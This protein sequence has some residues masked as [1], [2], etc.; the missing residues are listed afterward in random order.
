MTEIINPD[1]NSKTCI[2]IDGKNMV[3]CNKSSETYKFIK[4]GKNYVIEL[5]NTKTILNVKC[6]YAAVRAADMEIVTA[7]VDGKR[8]QN[9]EDCTIS[10]KY[11]NFASINYTSFSYSEKCIIY[12]AIDDLF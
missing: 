4:T 8:D 7:Y 2:F 5:P 3:Q 11:E 6:S 12:I 1:F 9:S 10:Y